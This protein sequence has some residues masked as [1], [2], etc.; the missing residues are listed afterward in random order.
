MRPKPLMPTRTV[1]LA[2]PS[3]VGFGP[4]GGGATAHPNRLRR[5][6]IGPPAP[7]VSSP[8]RCHRSPQGTRSPR[9]G[10]APTPTPRNVH[11]LRASSSTRELGR[12]RAEL[13][14]LQYHERA[15]NG[16]EFAAAFSY[17]SSSRSALRLASVLGMPRSAARL[18]AV[19][20]SRRIRP[21]TA[22]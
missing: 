6:G 7:L 19:A 10:N 21:A 15:A 1:M 13:H 4:P 2:F 18:S 9:S 8:D 3:S 20:S 16:G 11:L 22:S 14:D 12:K 5:V 17:S